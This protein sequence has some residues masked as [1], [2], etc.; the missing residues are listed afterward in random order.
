MAIQNPKDPLG[1]EPPDWGY[2]LKY[3]RDKLYEDYRR[4]EQLVKEM[5]IKPGTLY[6]AYKEPKTQ[7]LEEFTSLVVPGVGGAS[8]EAKIGKGSD[9]IE[10][11]IGVAKLSIKRDVL[12][13]LVTK[14]HEELQME[15]LGK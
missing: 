4:M 3:P 1:L 12:A 13:Q 8:F 10:V 15:K 2:E 7:K 5:Q 6:P 14:L 11:S 9:M